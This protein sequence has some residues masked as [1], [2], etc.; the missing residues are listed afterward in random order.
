MTNEISFDTQLFQ[1]YKNSKDIAE[2]VFTNAINMLIVRKV[3]PKTQKQNITAL[4][5]TINGNV[6][7][8]ETN[9]KPYTIFY[10]PHEVKSIKKMPQLTEFIAKYKNNHIIIIIK[11]ITKKQMERIQMLH[12]EC[13]VFEE[14]KLMLD[15]IKHEYIPKHIILT[16]QEKQQFLIDYNLKESQIPRLFNSDP[17]ARYYNL[18]IGTVCKIIRPIETS[19]TGV[20]Y[21]IVVR[22]DFKI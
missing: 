9:E 1:V 7:N 5:D 6:L 13:E 15:L 14:S 19:G 2:T 10:I 22:G 3:V 20:S 8:L 4:L 18:P 16:E 17:V 21:R 11:T 12:N